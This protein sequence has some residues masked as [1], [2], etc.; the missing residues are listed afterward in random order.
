MPALLACA[1]CRVEDTDQAR[2]TAASEEAVLQDLQWMGLQWDEG[3][4]RVPAVRGVQCR[5]QGAL[6]PADCLTLQSSHLISSKGHFV[7]QHVW[8]DRCQAGVQVG[9]STLL[10]GHVQ[11]LTLADP[12][13]PTASLSAG[14]SI[15]S[16][17]TS[18]SRRGRPTPASALTRS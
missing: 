7:W 3:G 5:Q 8:Q 16:T 9:L 1:A 10:H 6:P 11:G 14:T 2:S 17:W 13:A 15:R 12:M 4:P 18:W